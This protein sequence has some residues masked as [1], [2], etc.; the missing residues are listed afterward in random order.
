M[1]AIQAFVLNKGHKIGFFLL[2][3]KQ[4]MNIIWKEIYVPNHQ[5]SS[6]MQNPEWVWGFNCNLLQFFY[7]PE[8]VT[9]TH[10]DKTE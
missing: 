10:D 6:V 5:R 7:T 3:E 1:V 4:L 8:L 2:L 9:L